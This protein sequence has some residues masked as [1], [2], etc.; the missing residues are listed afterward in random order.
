MHLSDCPIPQS[1][2]IFV[3]LM[4]VVSTLASLCCLADSLDDTSAKCDEEDQKE[5]EKCDE[6]N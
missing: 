5:S 1:V 4:W 6:N 2:T 3:F